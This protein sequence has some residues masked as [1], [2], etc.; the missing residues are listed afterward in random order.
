MLMAVTVPM[1]VFPFQSLSSTVRPGWTKA[2]FRSSTVMSTT[3]L[4]VL[5]MVMT[6]SPLF[7]SMPGVRVQEVTEPSMGETA[8]KSASPFWASASFFWA[9]S[10]SFCLAMMSSS[11]VLEPRVSKASPADTSA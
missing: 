11:I 9:S 2:M 10:I 7:T 4:V 5:E 6:V 3:M 8:L 1:K